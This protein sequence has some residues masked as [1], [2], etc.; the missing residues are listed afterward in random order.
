MESIPLINSKQN[1]RQTK[2]RPNIQYQTTRMHTSLNSIYVSS[3]RIASAPH[4]LCLMWCK[5]CT[6]FD[7]KKW[8]DFAQSIVKW[9]F[10]SKIQWKKKKKE[11]KRK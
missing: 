5:I 10:A 1:E 4:V 8:H 2:C 11:K 3:V 9:S 6:S 7:F